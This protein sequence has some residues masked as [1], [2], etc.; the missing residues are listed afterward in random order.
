[1]KLNKYDALYML[2]WMNK[3]K[4]YIIQI[5]GIQLNDGGSQKLRLWHLL[6]KLVWRKRGR[7]WIP[8]DSYGCRGSGSVQRI[9]GVVC[10]QHELKLKATEL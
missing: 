10:N 4:S 6:E 5:S 9:E 2:N 8:V 1:M 7:I 3:S